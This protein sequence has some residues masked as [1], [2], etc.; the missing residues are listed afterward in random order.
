[1]AESI[2]Y[3]LDITYFVYISK[4]WIWLQIPNIILCIVGVIWIV[5]NPETPRYLLAVERFDDARKAFKWM[6]RWNGKEQDIW[7]EV[8]FEK[9]AEKIEDPTL[10]LR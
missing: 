6:A 5:V 7:N 4:N 9:E 2:V 1:M 10:A 8:I 3:L